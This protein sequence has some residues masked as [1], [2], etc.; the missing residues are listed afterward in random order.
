M[1][2]FILAALAASVVATPALAAPGYGNAHSNRTVV[3]HVDYGQQRHVTV[4]K[5]FKKQPQRVQYRKW[6][7][8]QRFDRHE[9]RNYRPVSNYR[10]YSR[11]YAPPR[12]YHWVQAD[13]GDYLLVAIATGLIAN[14]LLSQ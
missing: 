4:K 13:S 1:K 9:A 3:K 2:K 12:G 8:G 7:K 10:A 6:A 11:L 5:A 14:L